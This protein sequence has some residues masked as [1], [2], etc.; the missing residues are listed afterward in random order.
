MP[1]VFCCGYLIYIKQSYDQ[2]LIFSIDTLLLSLTLLLLLIIDVASK[3]DSFFDEMLEEQPYLK[4]LKYNNLDQSLSCLRFL[5][6]N[7]NP[8]YRSELGNREKE[9]FF[10]KKVTCV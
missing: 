4:R 8:I 5:D 1:L 2:T 7:N 9:D 6:E 10:R 3:D